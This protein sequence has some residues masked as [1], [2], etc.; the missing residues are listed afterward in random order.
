MAQVREAAFKALVAEV[1]ELKAQVE[2]LIK[3]QQNPKEVENKTTV[4]KSF[5]KKDDK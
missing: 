5:S 1:Q 3:S 4:K 2:E